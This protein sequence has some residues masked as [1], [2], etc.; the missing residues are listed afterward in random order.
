MDFL[1][2][3]HPALYFFLLLFG[4]LLYIAYTYFGELFSLQLGFL[5]DSLPFWGPPTLSFVFWY[6]W[7]DYLRSNTTF[8]QKHIL[9][10]IL[11]PRDIFKSPLAMENALAGFHVTTGE[12]QWFDKYV[13]GKMRT[14]WSLEIASIEG[15]LHFYVW[16][17]AQ[18]QPI[19]EAQLYGQYPGVEI[20]E[21]PDY[22]TDFP[23]FDPKR[24]G[25]WGNEFIKRQPSPY[26]IRTYVDFGLDKD[27]KEEFKVD[28]L[29]SVLE[30]MANIGKGEHMWLQVLIRSHSKK[31]KKG[32]LFGEIDWRDEG[33]EL[34]KEKLEE[35]QQKSPSTTEEGGFTYMRI[36]TKGESELLASIDRTTNK[37]A[38]DVGIRVIY[39]G[40]RENFVGPKITGV[41]NIMK[42][43]NTGNF[44]G[45]QAVRYAD[46]DFPFQDFMSIRTNIKRAKVLE[47]YRRRAFFHAPYKK[48]NFVLNAEELA[49]IYHF[50]GGVLQAPSV[51]RVPSKK[52][53]APSNLPR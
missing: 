46:V 31:H 8:E 41:I 10:E 43:Y 7:V 9:L 38:F 11:L 20:R 37:T 26:P 50:P 51:A 29:T 15:T 14:W 47:D 6:V 2:E 34:I 1:D 53:E 44:N 40:R 23:I 12:S 16:T 45:F 52:V 48:N 32:T 3:F 36:P 17:R 28:P 33:K 24:I 30:F 13:M 22:T 21:V 18:F 19:V 4:A 27:P 5:Y 35:L 49:T 42:P 39:A 25:L